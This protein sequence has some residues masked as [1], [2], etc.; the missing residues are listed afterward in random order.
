MEEKT[1]TLGEVGRAMR[2]KAKEVTGDTIA[3]SK[4]LWE[5]AA[6]LLIETDNTLTILAQQLE[7]DLPENLR[8]RPNG[9][10]EPYRA[11]AKLNFR[12]SLCK[13]FHFHN[14]EMRRKYKFCPGC[15][16]KMTKEQSTGF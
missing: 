3:S 15:G 5:E 7:A 16:A 11:G 8:L 12:C 14:G 4:S 10:W 1:L 6:T 2:K 13:K 9:K